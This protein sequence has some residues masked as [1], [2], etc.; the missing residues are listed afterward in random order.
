MLDQSHHRCP[1]SIEE[2]P[3]QFVK[4]W[5]EEEADLMASLLK[6]RN[7]QTII[8]F[9]SIATTIIFVIIRILVL[10]CYPTLLSQL[11]S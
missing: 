10:W 1:F 5:E 11:T 2:F 9:I 3:L 4:L 7:D 8:F 6:K